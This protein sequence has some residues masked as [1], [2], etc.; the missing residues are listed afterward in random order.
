H[1]TGSVAVAIDRDKHVVRLASGRL[2]PYDRLLLATGAVPRRLAIPGS[3]ALSY[4]RNYGDALALRERLRPGKRVALIGA[5]FIGLEV[6]ASAVARGAHVTV[7]EVAPRI[8]TRG[9]SS[10]IAEHVGARHRAAG[11]EIGTGAG[12]ARIDT[13]AAGPVVVLA[14]GARIE[15]DVVVAGIGVLPDIA[16]AE[17]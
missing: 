17:N 1:L 4:L 8:L 3:Q 14:D 10:E 9:V 16:L 5:G 13:P 12:T 15:A 11:V 6:A 7:I 2:I